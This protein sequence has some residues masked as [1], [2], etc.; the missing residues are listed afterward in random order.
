MGRAN[1]RRFLTDL[2]RTQ[3]QAPNSALW[4]I[5]RWSKQRASKPPAP[6]HLPPLRRSTSDPLQ[7]NNEEKTRILAEK[8]FPTTG[9]ADLS[10][11]NPEANRTRDIPIPSTSLP[12]NSS[13]QFSASPNNKAPGPDRIPNEALK[14]ILPAIAPRTGPCNKSMPGQ[15]QEIPT[16][17]KESTTIATRKEQK[18]DYSRYQKATARSPLKTRTCKAYREDRGATH[19]GRSRRTRNPPVEPD[20]GKEAALDNVSS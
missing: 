6:P 15:R 1:W 8:F 3:E 18:P 11:I 14:A 12:T 4:R 16:S 10:D 2:S 20:G 17:F 5:S 9:N 13:G 19:G 7:H